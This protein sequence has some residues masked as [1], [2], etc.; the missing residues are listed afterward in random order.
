MK[1][2]QD[3]I[4]YL[5]W[6]QAKAQKRKRAQETEGRSP[7]KRGW[8]PEIRKERMQEIGI[9]WWRKKEGKERDDSYTLP[10]WVFGGFVYQNNCACIGKKT[11][12]RMNER[13]TLQ[14]FS[15]LQ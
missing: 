1:A 11:P 12:Q 7:E 6:E 5:H 2:W 9:K 8:N 15:A 4:N 3:S 10:C 14:A 13:L